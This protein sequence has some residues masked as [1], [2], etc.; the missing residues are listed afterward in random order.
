MTAYCCSTVQNIWC[1]HEYT[2]KHTFS[3][4]TLVHIF[5]IHT[6]IHTHIIQY[7]SYN[8]RLLCC[9]VV[10]S[11]S[12]IVLPL[13][14][15]RCCCC[16]PARFCLCPF[17]HVYTNLYEFSTW[18]LLLCTILLLFDKNIESGRK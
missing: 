4:S 5:V 15:V 18:M 2:H 8:G 9:V 7:I 6:H 16:L 14:D 17:A 11:S 13:N 12:R 1:T 3:H 10:V